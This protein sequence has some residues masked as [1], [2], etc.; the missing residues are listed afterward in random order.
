MSHFHRLTTTPLCQSV[1]AALWFVLFL[2]VCT[3]VYIPLI[4][5]KKKVLKEKPLCLIAQRKSSAPLCASPS[6]SFLPSGLILPLRFWLWLIT[7]RPLVLPCVSVFMTTDPYRS[8]SK[9]CT[10]PLSP[11]THISVCVCRFQFTGNR[12]A[13]IWELRDELVW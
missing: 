9:H 12:F 1:P 5:P 11:T 3:C 10:R 8:T 13:Q 2:F 4:Q 7:R 6:S